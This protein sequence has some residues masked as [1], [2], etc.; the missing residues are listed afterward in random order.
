MERADLEQWKAREV[1]RLLSLVES[2][3]RYYQE[4]ASAVPVGLL[5]VGRELTILSANRAVRKIFNL[6]QSP[7]RASL[8]TLLPAA[9]AAGVPKVLDSGI[10]QVGISTVDPKTGRSL[11]IAI[12]GI[13]AW[14]DESGPEALIAVEDLSATEGNAVPVPGGPQAS[15][16]CRMLEEQWVQAER[17]QAV[18][19]LAARLA[20]DLNNML[21]I[22][23]G[24]AEEVLAG[25]PADSPM[26]AD[27]QEI[28]NANERMTTLTGHLLAFTRRQTAPAGTVDLESLLRELPERAGMEIRPPAPS[29]VVKADKDLLGQILLTL[30]E[31]EPELRVEASRV[32]IAEDLGQGAAPL[33]AGAYGVIRL[34][35][36]SR[37][38][39]NG[40]KHSWFETALPPKGVGDD[41]AT[42][43]TRAY[44]LIR[45]WGGDIAVTAEPGGG[46]LLRIFLEEVPS[47]AAMQA[48]PAHGVKG[49]TIL[50]VDDEPRIRALIQ[51]ILSRHGYRVIEAADGQEALAMFKAHPEIDLL[52]TDVMMPRMGG[53][54]LVEQLRRQT[55]GVKVLYVSGY[56]DDPKITAG[57]FPPGTAFLAKPFTI[58][59]LM[60]KVREVLVTNA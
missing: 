39:E 32:N 41:F 7:L 23:S 14:D 36:G 20:H 6:K 45:Q 22:A 10:P 48:E 12:V 19:K 57:K 27:V 53:A 52:I 49:Q 58:A 17:V 25:L 18:Q 50:V 11:R 59:A 26:R 15:A 46:T 54:E 16:E 47:A 29:I 34:S 35:M 9:V 30:T 28:V 3:R 43:L 21:M 38:M 4:I 40:A 8:D 13:R 51:K 56:T 31:G 44:T 24:H 33:R 55:I 60:S 42:R 37:R 2:E 5:V 1:A